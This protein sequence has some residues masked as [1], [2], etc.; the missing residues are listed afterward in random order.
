MI[1]VTLLCSFNRVVAVKPHWTPNTPNQSQS[2]PHTGAF[3]HSTTSNAA[4]TNTNVLGRI[5]MT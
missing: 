4:I 2:N 3:A 1:L 5:Q